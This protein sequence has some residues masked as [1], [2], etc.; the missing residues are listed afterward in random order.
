MEIASEWNRSGEFD[1]TEYEGRL[2]IA[3]TDLDEF[4]IEHGLTQADDPERFD[5]AKIKSACDCVLD[6][7]YDGNHGNRNFGENEVIF[8]QRE[9]YLIASGIWDIHSNPRDTRDQFDTYI[10][11]FLST[12]DEDISS[13]PDDI[14]AI[15]FE[16]DDD[17]L[18]YGDLKKYLDIELNW[19]SP[20][21]YDEYFVSGSIMLTEEEAEKL[22][23]I[24]YLEQM[25]AL[26]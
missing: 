7:D 26:L 23:E 5:E 2:F 18:K 3:D 10:K 19:Y 8:N 4:A 17:R 12:A 6:C 16:Y 25:T 22:E 21:H 14:I 13:D 15:A 1:D 24:F 11:D 20:A 9:L